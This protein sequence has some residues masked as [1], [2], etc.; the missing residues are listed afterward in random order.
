MRCPRLSELPAPPAGKTGWPWTE[1]SE[2]LPDMMP[3]PSASSG[4]VPWPKVSIVTPSYNQGQFIE[5]TIRSVLLQ[6]Y[7]DLEYII[8]DGGSTDES[9]EII[10]KYEP[11]LAHWVSEK[12]AGQA[13][14]INK[15]W[16][17]A[18][19]AAVS[20]LNSDD[21]LN[22]GML[23][24]AVGALF[25][26]PEIGFVYGDVNVIDKNSKIQRVSYGTSFVS[27]KIIIRGQNPVPQQGFLMKR[28]LLDRVGW[29]DKSMHFCMDF[30]YWVRLAL[31]GI[32]AIYLNKVLASFRHHE[33]T[34]TSALHKTRIENRQRVLEKAFSSS[35][36]PE[37]YKNFYKGA[38]DFFYLNAAYI[39]YKAGDARLTRFYAWQH[40]RGAVLKC[41]VKSVFLLF[42]ALFGPF[43][44]RLVQKL[45]LGSKLAAR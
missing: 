5:E 26:K 28:S 37:N 9:V 43:G 25:D 38:R 13:D 40:I 45:R 34:K 32:Q 14:A 16:E 4:Q 20:W 18:T 3:D 11:W 39:A 1:E 27:K 17:R 2:Q 44:I 6:G 23:A 7:P 15:G 22:C 30:D 29:L 8:M 42:F 24:V 41:S 35:C 12:D 21:T 31:N 19:G 10:R 36:L 33:G